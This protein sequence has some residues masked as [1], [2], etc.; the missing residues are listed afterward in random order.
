MS[1]AIKAKDKEFEKYIPTTQEKKCNKN[2]G[3]KDVSKCLRFNPSPDPSSLSSNDD[4][5]VNDYSFDNATSNDI[6]LSS[7]KLHD[8]N[9]ISLLVSNEGTRWQYND[10]KNEEGESMVIGGET[11]MEAAFSSPAHM[12]DTSSII[13]HN[14]MCSESSVE[15]SSQIAT[16]SS[17]IKDGATC[18]HMDVNNIFQIETASSMITDNDMGL[19][20]EVNKQS[21]M[22]ESSSTL[23]DNERYTKIIHFN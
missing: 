15:E 21:Y 12:G 7:T 23:R 19:I 8:D 20:I 13:T 17:I 22:G 6:A 10:M 4:R 18:G 5:E 2:V 3:P 9:S 1:S 11:L 16:S 14:D